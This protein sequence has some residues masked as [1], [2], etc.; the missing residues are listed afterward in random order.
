MSNTHFYLID[1]VEK[2]YNFQN[3]GVTTMIALGTY[4]PDHLWYCSTIKDKEG[5]VSR[6]GDGLEE[7]KGFHNKIEITVT[8]K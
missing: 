2:G 3:I 7:A 8:V 4:L 1:P 5:L 6:K